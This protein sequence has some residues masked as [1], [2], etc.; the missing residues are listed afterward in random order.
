MVTLLSA[1]W[2]IVTS[3][4]DP[5]SVVE[6]AANEAIL[7][8]ISDDGARLNVDKA[9]G[10]RLFSGEISFETGTTGFISAG[11]FFVSSS[12]RSEEGTRCLKRARESVWFNS[13]CNWFLM[14]PSDG[15]P[16]PPGDV[17]CLLGGKKSNFVGS[18]R[19]SWYVPIET[20][21]AD[22]F[23]SGLLRKVVVPSFTSSPDSSIFR[24][25]SER[26]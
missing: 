18:G 7:A 8:W 2:E 17:L 3:R 4:V 20:R 22:L 6:A 16:T 9:G 1:D 14:A 21:T 5:P 23:A 12:A 10:G 24:G 19:K 26:S 11:G 13:V 15:F 25:I